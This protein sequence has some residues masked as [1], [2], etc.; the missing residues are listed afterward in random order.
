IDPWD[1]ADLP[2]KARV[3]V[4]DAATFAVDGGVITSAPL[5]EGT[6][7]IDAAE[8]VQQYVTVRMSERFVNSGGANLY[9]VFRL[10]GKSGNYGVASSVGP[11]PTPAHPA[12]GYTTSDDVMSNAFT[13]A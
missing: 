9:I 8:G 3:V 11:Y 4:Y 2:T 13:I 12:S 1:A 10:D 6:A 7:A 5:A